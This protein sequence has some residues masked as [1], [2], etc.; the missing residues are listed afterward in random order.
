MHLLNCLLLSLTAIKAMDIPNF[1][2]AEGAISRT[3][4]QIIPHQISLSSKHL[5]EHVFFDSNRNIRDN[6]ALLKYFETEEFKEIMKVRGAA[7]ELYD[8]QSWYEPGKSN[9]EILAHLRELAKDDFPEKI[10][11]PL[12]ILSFREFHPNTIDLLVK[13]DAFNRYIDDRAALQELIEKM[14]D[15]IEVWEKV[16]PRLKKKL[17]NYWMQ[18]ALNND[19]VWAIPAFGKYLES[20]ENGEYLSVQLQ[21]SA[22]PEKT[23]NRIAYL[24]YVRGLTPTTSLSTV[25][26]VLNTLYSQNLLFLLYNSPEYHGILND[27]FKAFQLKSMLVGDII[28]DPF[29]K[30]LKVAA[31]RRYN[32]KFDVL[33]SLR[34][35]TPF[36]DFGF[37]K[38]RDFKPYQVYIANYERA[39]ELYEEIK[40]NPTA[41]KT[42]TSN[43]RQMKFLRFAAYSHLIPVE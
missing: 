2:A 34:D 19:N 25:A 35:P 42:F 10:N 9:T 8:H 41:Y 33:N 21:D 4:G 11:H 12:F 7:L 5:I 39:T 28:E 23:Q 40:R 31:T 20:V 37:S 16:L 3:L 13:S 24:F 1:V 15:S 30:N 43:S 18:E 6:Q 36:K 29:F 38:L 14:H 32:G 22:V 17:A 26:K 27:P